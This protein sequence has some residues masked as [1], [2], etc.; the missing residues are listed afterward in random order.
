VTDKENLPNGIG[1]DATD[2]RSHARRPPEH[3]GLGGFLK[4]RWP[5]L[6]GVAAVIVVDVVS[7]VIGEDL[8]LY[9]L[10]WGVFVIGVAYLVWGAGRGALQSRG[11]LV[12]QTF[13]AIGF[14]SVALAALY[15]DP[16]LGRY[17]LA[18]GWFGHGLWDVAHHVANRVVPRWYAEFCAVA[19]VLAG[20]AILFAP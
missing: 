15:A 11:P 12:L 8:E 5:T 16:D 10:A 13:G 20:C 18:A 17:V 1:E 4:H 6:G 14:G 3:H 2:D 9:V 19:D 7:R